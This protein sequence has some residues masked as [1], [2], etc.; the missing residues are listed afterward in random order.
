M[1][2]ILTNPDA[3]G[4]AGAVQFATA[5]V[6]SGAAAAKHEFSPRIGLAYSLNNKTVIRASYGI[7][8]APG[9]YFNASVS[10]FHQGYTSV[11]TLSNSN[12]DYSP[13]WTLAG[14]WPYASLPHTLDLTSGYGTGGGVQRLDP[15]DARPAYMQSRV[16]QIERQLPSN[17]VLKV[18]YIGNRG[19][20]LQS[21]IDVNNEMPPWDMS[22]TIPDPSATNGH[23]NGTGLAPAFLNPIADPRV[24]ALP[25][26]ANM[27]IDTKSTSI[28]GLHAPFQGFYDVMGTG[29]QLGQALLP[30][31][32]YQKLSTRR[33][34]E[35]DGKS[36][37][38]ALKV[39]L[40]KRM[41]N[42]LTLL[43]SYTWSKVLT[44]AASQFD[45]FSGYDQNSYDQRAQ[46]GL[47]IN[48]YPMNL[49]ITYSYEL[50]F[51][52]GKK[53]ASTGGAV[54]KV[55]G[56]WKVSAVQNYQ[57]GP[58]QI[59]SQPCFTGGYEGNNDNGGG[60]A[61]RPN[62]LSGVPIANP[63]RNQPGFD[64]IHTSLVNPAAFTLT[65]NPLNA[66]GLGYQSYFGDG[67]P[68][69]GGA[70]RRLPFLNEDVSIIKKTQITERV[71]VE[72][73]ADFLNIFNRT[74]L[75]LGTGG[76]MYGSSL[77]N[78]IG[79]GPFGIANSQ[80]NQPREIQFGLKINY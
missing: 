9:G 45:E 18:A 1:T 33:L 26:V 6:R 16:F 54:G 8:F 56:G 48:D 10:N 42:G 79:G 71:N 32:Q 75:G 49:V 66:P 23:G 53:F 69:L 63:A 13:T 46:K 11:Q 38:N 29:A 76:D 25:I 72:F 52:P 35:G 24:Q 21:R 61:C 36:D 80:T 68:L 70:G 43:V 28:S 44:N 5:Q 50:P 65:P 19:T 7:L 47:S 59:F 34:Y 55:I 14:G 20:R 4:H 22:L 3:G 15:Q 74:V 51:G 64:P 12:N 73:R 27:P 17:M 78:Q 41:S 31:P 40:D 58:P 67:P 30:F 57:S 37:Y 60:F 39:D 77:G 2:P 62:I